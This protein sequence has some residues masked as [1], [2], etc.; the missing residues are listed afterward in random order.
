MDIFKNKGKEFTANIDG[1]NCKG[2]VEI[3]EQDVYLC[4]SEKDGSPC[5][6]KQGFAFSWFVG[7]ASKNFLL[8][9]DYEVQNLI[10]ND[11]EVNFNDYKVR[12]TLNEIEVK[13]GLEK[14]SL[15]IV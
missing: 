1:V 2:I 11:E 4:Q 7:E 3:E 9:K 15:I 13:L 8:D 10:I 12:M 5:T 14:N 6:N